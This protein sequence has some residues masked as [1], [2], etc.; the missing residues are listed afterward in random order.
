MLLL[1]LKNKQKI[2]NIAGKCCRTASFR[3]IGA[4]R[5]I[6]IA[7]GAGPGAAAPKP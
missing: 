4:N 7:W 6:S 2:M 5:Q 1:S 3:Y